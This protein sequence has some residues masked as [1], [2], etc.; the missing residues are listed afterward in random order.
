MPLPTNFSS[1][2]HLQDVA[3]K[4]TNK[5]VRAYFK[6]VGGDDW[7]PH[8]DTDRARLR[9][10]CTHQEKDS[11]LETIC[12]LQLFNIELGASLE[13]L[14]HFYGMP[15]QDVHVSFAF[16]PEVL[17]IFKEKY[18]LAKK[19]KRAP[20]T[21]EYRFR[22]INETTSSMTQAKIHQLEVKIQQQFPR[23]YVFKSGRYK[24]SYY[25]KPAGYQSVIEAYSIT[26]VKELI[27]KM[28]NVSG[29]E[30]DWSKLRKSE[31]VSKNFEADEYVMVLGKR[32]KLPKRRVITEA[33]LHKVELKMHGNLK[34]IYLYRRLG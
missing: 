1:A 32:K 3:L 15:T 23:T 14:G 12:R 21:F 16:R 7:E 29:G 6:D 18:E 22:L 11:L 10:A 27:S 2:E 8:L 28:H 5:R 25:N 34:D 17:F 19:K 30:P 31:F 26:E 33:F 24:F 4:L 13:D 20:L 9:V